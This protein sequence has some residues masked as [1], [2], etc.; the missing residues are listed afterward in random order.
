MVVRAQASSLK[1]LP[2]QQVLLLLYAIL[3]FRLMNGR[4]EVTRIMKKRYWIP[5]LVLALIGLTYLAGPIPD[6]PH[7]SNEWMEVPANLRQLEDSI[8]RVENSLPLRPDNHARILWKDSVPQ[9]TEYAFVYLHGFT[10]SYRDAYP[11]NVNVAKEL[12]TN[13]YLARWA[14]HGFR[15]PYSMNNF[16]PEAAWLSAKKAL[17]IGHRLGRKV[18]L[19]STSTGGTLAMKLAATF[20]DSVHALI[21]ISPNLEDDQE[22]AFLLNSPWGNEI[23]HLVSLGDYRKIVHSKEAA[24]QYWDTKY[25]AQALIDLQMLVETMTGPQIFGDIQCPVLTLYY[26]KNFLQ[27]DEHVEVDEYPETYPMLGTPDS[28]KVLVPLASPGSHFIGSDIKSNN[29][30]TAQQRILRFCREKLKMQTVNRH[31]AASSGN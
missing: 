29:Y 14:G 3:W 25:P 23:A 31:I 30:H 1:E 9:V 15:I 2:N 19:L 8:A 7:Y 5:L 21:N 26:H 28:L 13:I 24:T 4:A 22:G 10:G 20:Q 17:A 18:I 27:E 11:L 16:S 6:Q 12:G